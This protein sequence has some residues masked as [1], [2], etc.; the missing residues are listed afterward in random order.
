[1]RIVDD[2]DKMTVFELLDLRSRSKAWLLTP[3]DEVVMAAHIQ[4]VKEID[5]EL[6]IRLACAKDG[7]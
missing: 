4:I 1:M 5:V 6:T 7:S 2:I 3:H